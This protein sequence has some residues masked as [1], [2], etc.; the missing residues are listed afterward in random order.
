MADLEQFVRDSPPVASTLVRGN[1]GYLY[2]RIVT[3]PAPPPSHK[4]RVN[5]NPPS[6]NYAPPASDRV[7]R[8]NDRVV[9]QRY[10]D[11]G[12]LPSAQNGNHTIVQSIEGPPLSPRSLRNL[13]VTE[14][15]RSQQRME[16]VPPRTYSPIQANRPNADHLPANTRKRAYEEYEEPDF[17]PQP[18]QLRY[19]TRA[20]DATTTSRNNNIESFDRNGYANRLE[21]LREVPR[22]SNYPVDTRP[23]DHVVYISSSPTRG[24]TDWN[25]GLRHAPPQAALSRLPIFTSKRQSLEPERRPL[26]ISRVPSNQSRVQAAPE[27]SRYSTHEASNMPAPSYANS[28]QSRRQPFEGNYPT[29]EE[30]SLVRPIR[31]EPVEYLERPHERKHADP[32]YEPMPAQSSRHAQPGL[33]PYSTFAP[34]LSNTFATT[35]QPLNS[36]YDGS[37][38]TRDM[39]HRQE[40]RKIAR[41]DD[42]DF[43]N[44]QR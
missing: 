35:V 24:D 25:G 10:R 38:D 1:D 19:I 22:R 9:S 18:R 15:V 36:A 26:A 41:N 34:D 4:P 5:T 40:P 27:Y 32:V 2:E 21:P 8:Q 30:P 31:Y 14:Q 11:V 7:L 44:D 29:T 6:L 42:V 33:L 17:Q 20:I 3:V 12:E 37:F 28:S 23:S 16:R 43:P 13:E 39:N